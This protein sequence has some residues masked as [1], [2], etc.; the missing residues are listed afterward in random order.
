[1]EAAVPR[2]ELPRLDGHGRHVEGLRR[3]LGL[4][5]RGDREGA[6]NAPLRPPEA[7]QAALQLDGLPG[8]VVEQIEGAEHRRL[9][10]R[11]VRVDDR[12]HPLPPSG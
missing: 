12:N 2:P 8:D 3:L 11:T 7:R 10:R 6:V 4:A 5:D 9:R 1:L